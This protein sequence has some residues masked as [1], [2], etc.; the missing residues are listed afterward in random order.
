MSVRRHDQHRVYAH[1]VPAHRV[2]AQ[3]HARHQEHAVVSVARHR[4]E[5]PSRELRL[6]G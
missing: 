6:N 4:A 5:E 1:R 2:Y 3:Q